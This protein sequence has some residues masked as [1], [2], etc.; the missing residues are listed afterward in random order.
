MAATLLTWVFLWVATTDDSLAPWASNHDP[1]DVPKRHIQEITKG[2]A[3]YFVVQNGTMDG[4]NCGSPQGVWQPFQQTWESNRSVLMENVGETD[5]VN[6]WLSNGRNDF[7]S[8]DE[9]VA[10]AM[11]FWDLERLRFTI[12]R[13]PEWLSIDGATGLLSGTPDRVG[14]AE[15]V[16]ALTL[17]RDERRLDEAALKWGIEK[18]VSTRPVTVG[19]AIQGFAIEIG[20]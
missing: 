13:G 1:T 5:V 20:L 7:R 14:K 9:I 16:V 18:V 10:R 17:E 2:R 4:R 12:Q 6:P 3:E 11:N 8:L 19:S 15:V